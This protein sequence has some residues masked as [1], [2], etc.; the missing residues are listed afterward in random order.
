MH[1]AETVGRWVHEIGGHA[2]VVSKLKDD[3]AKTCW[4]IAI[5]EGP[6][7]LGTY[8]FFDEEFR[9]GP[10]GKLSQIRRDIALKAIALCISVCA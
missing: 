7:Y 8:G 10:L 6:Q 9:I 5:H 3:V 1:S 4:M 2:I